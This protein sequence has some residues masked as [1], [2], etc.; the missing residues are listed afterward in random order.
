MSKFFCVLFLLIGTVAYGATGTITIPDD[1]LPQGPQGP[2]GT[3]GKDGTVLTYA[4]GVCGA[5]INGTAVEW[6]CAEVG[7]PDPTPDPSPDPTPEPTPDPTPVV[8]CGSPYRGIPDPCAVL[9]FDVYADYTPDRVLTGNLGNFTLTANGTAADPYFVDA[10]AATFSKLT[11]SGSYIIVQGGFVDAT[12]EGPVRSSAHHTV[13]RDVEVKGINGI[14]WGGGSAATL[15]DN[16]VWLRGSIHNFGML[17]ASDP[18]NDQHGFKVFRDNIWILDLETYELSGDGVQVGDA[19]SGNPTNIYI[20]GGYYHNNRENAVDVKNST[21][22]VV[23]GIT[24]RYFTP[25][26]SSNGVAVVIHNDALGSKVYDSDLSDSVI[27]LAITGGSGHVVDGNT[28]SGSS[29]ALDLRSM[30]GD[31]SNNVLNG[32]CR[33]SPSANGSLPPEC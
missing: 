27:A 9:G 1:Q 26:Q 24:A 12:N 16:S 19:N 21:N 13:F 11:V 33:A 8:E 25:T 32:P 15:G 7:A 28:L 6:P 17:G 23:S 22:V 5:L 29:Y 18:E 20:G 10:S 31:F 30:S 3:D 2:A 14:N 4:G